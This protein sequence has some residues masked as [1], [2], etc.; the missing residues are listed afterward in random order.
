M[1]FHRLSGGP[2]NLRKNTTTGFKAETLFVER[3]SSGHPSTGKEGA[4]RM[5]ELSR[6]NVIEAKVVY[7]GHPGNWRTP[8]RTWRLAPNRS[9]DWKYPL[10]GLSRRN[11]H[12]CPN[13]D[14]RGGNVRRKRSSN[15]SLDPHQG[16]SRHRYNTECDH[17]CPHNPR[18]G[19]NITSD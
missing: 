2:F 10:D 9:W 11:L 4:N 12:L 6:P 14:Y 5:V 16:D 19:A 3:G 13:L 15:A 7:N 8:V 18:H 17:N 1:T